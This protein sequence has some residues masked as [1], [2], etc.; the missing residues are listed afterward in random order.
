MAT[1]NLVNESDSIITGDDNIVI[2][3]VIESK[4]GGASLDVTGFVP[5]V[6]KAGHVI[7]EETSSGELKPMPLASGEAAYAAL[8]VGHTYHG[9]LIASIPANRPM[10][11]IMYRG[12][13][14]PVA[15]PYDFATIQAA[16]KTALPLIDFRAD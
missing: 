9:I 16:V 4:R 2:V 11:G 13:V 8:P 15:A 12:T 7:I 10:A 5:T 6:I 3:N 14:N 1:V